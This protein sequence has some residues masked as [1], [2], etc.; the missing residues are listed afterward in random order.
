MVYK[1]LFY[2]GSFFNILVL[3]KFFRSTSYCSIIVLYYFILY[4]TSNYSALCCSS[5]CTLWGG[6]GTRFEPGTGGLE[7]GTLTTRPPHPL[8]KF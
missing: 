2:S 1:K 5:D 7:A 8:I 3:F 4:I 6:P